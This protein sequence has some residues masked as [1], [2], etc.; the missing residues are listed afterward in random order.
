MT[1]VPEIDPLAGVFTTARPRLSAR[2]RRIALALIR[3]L[4][5]RARRRRQPAR[6]RG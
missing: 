4:A 6:E 2:E 5:L 1:T 3:R